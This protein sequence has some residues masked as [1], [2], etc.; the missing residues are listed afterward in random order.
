MSSLGFKVGIPTWVNGSVWFLSGDLPLI[1]MGQLSSEVG[2]PT[3]QLA[4]RSS[5]VGSR[6]Y[7]VACPSSE[8]G[9]P[10]SEVMVLRVK[11][12]KNSYITQILP[13]KL[14]LLLYGLWNL[15]FKVFK[16]LLGKKKRPD[17]IG[18]LFLVAELLCYKVSFNHL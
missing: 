10:T 7:Q 13:L 8:V 18:T 6:T 11:L 12:F 4:C 3:Y 5:K 15:F 1:I 14:V 17:I 2:I 9:T 16:R